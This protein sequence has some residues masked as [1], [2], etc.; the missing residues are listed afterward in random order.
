ML[1]HSS[2]DDRPNADASTIA[3][4]PAIIPT[5]EP[6]LTLLADPKLLEIMRKLDIELACSPSGVPH[7][8]E[9]DYFGYSAAPPYDSLYTLATQGGGCVFLLWVCPNDGGMPVVFLGSEGERAK[10][11]GSVSEF[12]QLALSLAPHFND[13]MRELPGINTM[14]DNGDILGASTADFDVPRLL[15]LLEIWSSGDTP[16]DETR[17]VTA[18]ARTEADVVLDALGLSRLSRE[19]ALN[20]LCAAHLN[21]PRFAPRSEE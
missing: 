15:E 18:Q 11:G 7:I 2:A 16:D 13:V 12:L 1:P 21:P 3:L 8:H 4:P 19:D 20:A 10:L 17:Q 14:P 5:P 6:V 9:D